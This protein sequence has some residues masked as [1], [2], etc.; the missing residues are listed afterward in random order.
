MYNSSDIKLFFSFECHVGMATTGNKC[1]LCPTHW[2]NAGDY[3][4]GHDSIRYV[5]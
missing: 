2:K 1:P 3:E 5:I 4:I